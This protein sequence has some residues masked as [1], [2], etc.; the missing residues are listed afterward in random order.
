MPP[1]IDMMALWPTD[2]N[3][4]HLIA[5]NEQG[6]ADPG[7]VRIRISDGFTETILKG[8]N[9]CDPVK[10][11]AWGTILLRRRHDGVAARAD[12]TCLVPPA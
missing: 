6:T 12:K 2:Q 7:L 5:C 9:S 10:R 8:T 11:T 3:P 1:N 4:T